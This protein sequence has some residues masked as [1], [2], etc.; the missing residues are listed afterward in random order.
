MKQKLKSILL[1][2]DD[3]ATNYLHKLIIKKADCAE[4]VHVELNGEAA[5]KYLTTALQG[6]YPRPELIF[7]DINMPLMNGWDF[8]EEYEKLDHAQQG[9]QVIVMLS[10]SLVASDIEK[11]KKYGNISEFLSKPLTQDILRNV[12]AKYFPQHA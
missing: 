7:L 9:G 4:S 11:A 5:I 1:V 2:D 8:L 10:T 6:V 3:D 12:I